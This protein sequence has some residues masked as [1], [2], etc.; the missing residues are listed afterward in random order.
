M[1]SVD[2]ETSRTPLNKRA[3]ALLALH[4][5]LLIYSLVS[6]F[7]KSAAQQEFMSPQFIA[8]YIGMIA[9]LGIYAVGWQQVIKHLSLTLAFANKAVTVI[10]GILWGWVFFGEEITFTMLIGAVIVMAG[11]VLFGIEDA[12]EQQE[13]SR[14]QIDNAA[15]EAR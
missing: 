3:L 1:T 2:T 14:E 15:G 11:V 13:V 5:L 6:F 9:M 12:R 7:S 10:W 8:F 4:V